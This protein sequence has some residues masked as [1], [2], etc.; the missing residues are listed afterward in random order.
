MTPAKPLAPQDLRLIL[1][2]TAP[3]WEEARGQRIFITGGIGFF[4]CWLLE[5]FCLINNLLR[6][7][8]RATVLTRDPEAFERKSPHL[9]W[10]PSVTL[11]RGDVRSFAFPKGEYQYIIHAATESSG[12]QATESPLET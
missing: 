10:D 4:G 8:A 6:L 1:E 12:K 5:S 2:H 9:A 7:N 11:V 3:L